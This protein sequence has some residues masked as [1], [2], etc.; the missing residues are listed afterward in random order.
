ML[1]F[2]HFYG[3]KKSLCP[4]PS[5]ALLILPSCLWML[6]SLYLPHVGSGGQCGGAFL[7]LRQPHVERWPGG[8]GGWGTMT[9]YLGNDANVLTLSYPPLNWTASV[10]VQVN[11]ACLCDVWSKPLRCRKD[12][13]AHNIS[14]RCSAPPPLRV[15]AI[16]HT[17]N[18][19]NI[20]WACKM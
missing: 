3:I 6:I 12:I 2:R 5:P 11:G 8:G 4:S 18:G 14:L 7:P 15:T 19:V 1:Y 10:N 16:F 17:M 13:S 9:H 20:W